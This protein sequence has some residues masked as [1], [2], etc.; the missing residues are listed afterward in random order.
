M[1]SKT[2]PVAK[3]SDFERA[4]RDLNLVPGDDEARAWP[5]LFRGLANASWGLETTLE[6]SHPNERCNATLSLRRYYD[7]IFAARSAV[8]TF[9]GRTWGVLPLPPE[10]E[11]L[12]ADPGLS[13][14]D[15]KMNTQPEIYEYLV[16]LRHHGFPSPLLDWTVSP[17]VAALFAFDKVADHA[18]HVC[19]YAVL[20]SPG[21]GSY[22]EH[23]YFVGPYMRT[24]QRH[25]LQQ[26]WYSMCV[27]R[28]ESG[29]DYLFQ[30]QESVMKSDFGPAKQL[31]KFT[32][33]IAE[34]QIALQHL[35][36][37]N[38]NPFSLF[39]SEDSLVS[40]IARR[41]CLFKRW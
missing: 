19:V 24:H 37:M 4:I 3:W 23:C 1:P 38:I 10:F 25:H 6:R 27:G 16:Y 31:L 39:A 41:E 40:T 30:P 12:L 9:S 35:D 29:K 32:I 15:I 11:L 26:C 20:P 36:L 5:P 2:I 28:D 8:E 14:L 34:R 7:K 17:Y 18:Q 22:H 33:P 13:W 21:A